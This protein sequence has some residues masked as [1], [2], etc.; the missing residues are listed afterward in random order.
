[1]KKLLIHYFDKLWLTILFAALLL[2]TTQT[3]FACSCSFFWPSESIIKNL[4]EN[5][6]VVIFGHPIKNVNDTFVS[7]NPKYMGTT[8][9]FKVESVLKGELKSDTIFINQETMGNCSM[10]FMPNE[11]YV[12]FGK[13]IKSYETI[14]ANDYSS[15]TQ[16]SYQSKTLKFRDSDNSLPIFKN[17]T[18]KY[19][20][21]TTSQCISFTSQDTSVWEYFNLKK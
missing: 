4:S 19:Y 1:M 11:K 10:H 12:I 6:D 14:G 20:T 7:P 18:S 2:I 5:S 13:Q 16:Y 8:I 17:L 15:S 3:S 9:L 21:I